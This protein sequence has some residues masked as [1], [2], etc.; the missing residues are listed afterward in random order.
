VTRRFALLAAL[1]TG[2]LCGTSAVLYLLRDPLPRFMERRSEIAS[3][4]ESEITVADDYQFQTATITAKSGLSFSLT[5][6]RQVADTTSRL[7]AVIILGGHLSGKEAARLVGETPGVLVAAVSYPFTGDLRPSQST[8]S[9]QIPRIRAAFL[10]TPPALMLALDYLLARPDV[11]AQHVEGVGVSL[12]APF[13][14]IAGALDSRFSRVWAIHGSGGSYA[15]L[16]ANMKRTISFK[17]ARVAAAGLANVI[18]AGPTL[19][20]ELPS[21]VHHGQC[22]GRRAAAASGRRRVVRARIAP[23]GTH[24]DVRRPYSRRRADHPAPG[25]DRPVASAATERQLG[26]TASGL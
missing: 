15:P 17:P 19:A 3:V 21:T 24:L 14:T 26:A 9:R 13:M 1:G 11:D 4:S 7:P 22:D 8:F 2:M 10:D 12:G 23:E 6:R 18:I 25:P 20:P 16:E 5:V